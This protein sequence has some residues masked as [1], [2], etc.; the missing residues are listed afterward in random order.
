[1]SAFDPIASPVDFF[2]IAGIRSPGIAELKGV[3]LSRQI[4][5]RRGFGLM[6]ATTVVKGQKLAHFSADIKLV[7]SAEFAAWDSFASTLARFNPRQDRAHGFTFDHPQTSQ[8]GIN[9]VVV[10]EIGSPVQTADGE[11]TASIKFVEHRR[12][13]RMLA[14]TDGSDEQNQPEDPVDREI[15]RLTAQLNEMADG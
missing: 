6:G 4:D 11:W 10:E 15:Q 8:L 9:A 2:T 1:M 3:A 14:T 12:P 5:E 13:R 7:T